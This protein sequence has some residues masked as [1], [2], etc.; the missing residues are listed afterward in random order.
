MA[1]DR[2]QRKLAAIL[3]ADVVGYSRLMGEDESGTLKRLKVLRKELFAPK[4]A[5]HN[6]RVVKLMG[7][8]ALVEFASVVDA[9]TCAVAVQRAFDHRNAEMP[10]DKRIDLR[11]G[12]NLGDV[13]I[14]GSDI[15]GDGVNVAARLQELAAPGGIAL[16]ATAHEHAA[17]KVDVS[18]KDGGEQELK[19]IVMPVRVYH[20]CDEN[21]DG[22]PNLVRKDTT[23]ALADKP[24]I[25]V[26][27]F[28]NMSGDPEQGY[29][30]D[31]ITED[32]ITNLSYIRWLFVIARNSSFV[33]KD[34]AIDVREVAQE[35][36]VRYVLEGSVRKAANT[37]RITAQL[38]DASTS[39]HLWAGRYDRDLTDIF[40]VQDEIT[41]SVV[42]AIEPEILAA[43][44][45]RARTRS[46][47][48]IDAWDMVMQ[49]RSIYWK[50]SK[51]DSDAAITLLEE[52][53]AK[54]P[55]YGPAHSMLAFALLFSGHVGW[56]QL[57]SVR[58]RAHALATKAINIDD[59]DAWAHIALGYSHAINRLP[60]EAILEC[61]K[62]V[63]LNP[64]FAL[65]Y[66]YRGLTL[67]HAG[68]S[69]EAIKDIDMAL[70]LSPK[71]AQNALFVT[72]AGVA[73][74][75]AGRY[76]EAATCAEEGIR[77]RPG[78]VAGH[79]VQCAA[80]AQGGRMAEA[81]AALQKIKQLQPDVSAT[82]LKKT[83]PYSTPD[84]LEN[85]ID[86]LR[87]AGLPE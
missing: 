5:E 13:I 18:F 43:E 50:I 45:L 86:G 52:A 58:D 74:Y 22:Q 33:F 35:L 72:A 7:D 62:A 36:G 15:Y 66:G 1:E 71:D 41:R 26:L 17:A 69:E 53:I 63:S 47:S 54:Y 32:I 8:G 12:V 82:L 28:N 76:D 34:R 60:D 67:A 73:H 81:H 79:R 38:I 11:I 61:S 80:L 83:L 25:A 40:A 10:S 48:D 46:E 3:V 37:V 20:W 16:S 77:I 44:G 84:L 42:A 57:E 59:Q 24:S 19:N 75:L 29:F 87:K 55:D 23:P 65:A 64:N 27:P 51:D 56:R 70:S 85:F 6:G 21:S 9:V 14:E 39:A 68:R 49:A 4:I 78:F 30:S 31:G 2:V